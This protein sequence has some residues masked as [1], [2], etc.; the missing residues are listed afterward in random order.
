MQRYGGISRYFCELMDYFSK[1]DNINFTI[2]LRHSNNENLCNIKYLNKNWSNKSVG[3]NKMP[4]M[5]NFMIYKLLNILK[6]NEMESIKQL[7]QNDFDIFHPT[8]YNP[9]FRQHLGKKP[10][11]L[12]VHDMIHEIYPQYNSL[13]DPT[14]KWKKEIIKKADAII[15]ISQNTKQDIIRFTD[16]DPDL[17]SVIYHGN[18]LDGA[19]QSNCPE[20]NN[21]ELN[22]N[23]DYLLFI[24]N[25]TGHKNFNFFISSIS[26]IL[27]MYDEL[28]VLCAG[29]GPFTRSEKKLFKKLKIHSKVRYLKINGGVIRYL[30]QNAKAFIFPS[31]YE[32][33]GFPILEAFTCGC[34]II[35]SNLSSFPEIAKDAA[36]YIDPKNSESIVCGVEKVLFDHE[37]RDILI[38]KG[39][40]RVKFFSWE[41]TTSQT[42]NVYNRIL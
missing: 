33:F 5:N 8:Y 28:Y 22:K 12:T 26:K 30:Y 16:V 7:K 41:K 36:C 17:I 6:F 39:Y 29:G 13:W 31:L 42:I 38:D 24:G 10:F 34:P 23:M 9:Y 14:Q 25:R 32:G 15:A 11:V 20:K 18:P 2:S 4:F 1:E 21:F 19:I 3:L 40:E 35:I 37:F 27:H